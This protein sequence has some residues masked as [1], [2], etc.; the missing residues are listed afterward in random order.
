MTGKDHRN[1]R[2]SLIRYAMLAGDLISLAAGLVLA[3]TARYEGSLD[4]MN[5]RGLLVGITLTTLIFPVTST[6][7]RLHH[8][9]YGVGSVE[10]AKSL[11]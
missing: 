7:L 2:W 9:R 3:T 8:G 10:E 4:Q 11:G 1:W 5:T 6:V